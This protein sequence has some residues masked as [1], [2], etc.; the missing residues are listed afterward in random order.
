[1]QITPTTADAPLTS[2]DVSVVIAN[3]NG[4]KLLRDCLKSI[5]HHTKRVSFEV[6]VSDDRSPDRSVEFVRRHFPHVIVR[7]NEKN[8]GFARTNN[9]ALPYVR[10]RYTFLLNND[11]ILQNDA[12]S[13]LVH[14][15][16]E[17][18]DVGVAGGLLINP[19]GTLQ[20]AYGDFPSVF[21]ELGRALNVISRG[22]WQWFPNLAVIP[23]E[24]QKLTDVGY[25]VGANLMIRTSLARKLGLFDE[26]F[27]SYFEDTDL[28]YRVHQT[29][30]RV[31]FTS[32]ARIVH[33]FGATFG[34][35]DDAPSERKA[36][37]MERG[38]VR[39]CRKHYSRR[40]ASAV[41]G[42]HRWAYR[43][44][45]FLLRLRLRVEPARRHLRWRGPLAAN[46]LSYSC[47]RD[48]VTNP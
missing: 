34:K 37:L 36:R 15:F 13:E 42:L 30:F 27:E 35:N 12:I 44:R 19:D 31:V 24:T 39:F 22:V 11:T 29:G 14:V 6:I 5:Y 47:F 18:V 2:C 7:V 4:E 40:R 41:L 8:S 17:N 25:I 48:A 20:H 32:T 16:D 26:A 45:I 1:M 46:E 9:A 3:W 33:L 43:W 10:G 38:F 21:T 28:C 23:R